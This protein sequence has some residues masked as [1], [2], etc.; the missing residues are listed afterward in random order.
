MGTATSPFWQKARSVRNKDALTHPTPIAVLCRWIDVASKAAVL[1]GSLRT[2]AQ[3]QG[4]RGACAAALGG[5]KKMETRNGRI[6][7]GLLWYTLRGTSMEWGAI[8]I[9]Q[10]IVLK[11][12]AFKSPHVRS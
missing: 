8:T 7:V 3:L 10:L 1:P 11:L 12:A 6:I 4:A 2:H 5:E 9:S